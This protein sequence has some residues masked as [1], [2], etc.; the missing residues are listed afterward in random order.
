MSNEDLKTKLSELCS[1]LKIDTFHVYDV[2][3]INHDPHPYMIGSKHVAYASDHYN[4]MLGKEVC[5]KIGCAHPG[6]NLPY[7][8][9]TSIKS[10]FIQLNRNV[11]PEELQ[12]DLV[13][14]LEDYNNIIDGI[15]F[16]DTEEQFR[17]NGD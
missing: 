10:M 9:H 13:A 6:C 15:T 11:D 14:L 8:A 17:V 2:L 4:G 1:E 3:D 5:E 12:S 16:V 7:S